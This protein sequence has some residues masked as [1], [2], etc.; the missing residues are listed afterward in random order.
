M[1]QRNKMNFFSALSLLLLLLQLGHCQSPNNNNKF[2]NINNNNNN[3][4]SSINN[5]NKFSNININ[6]NNNNNLKP[7]QPI[8]QPLPPA[9]ANFTFIHQNLLGP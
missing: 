9:D 3:K 4:F 6:N 1:K 8:G 7:Q 2:S 5:N